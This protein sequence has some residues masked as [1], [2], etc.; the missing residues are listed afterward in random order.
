VIGENIS[1]IN[2]SRVGGASLTTEAFNEA[3]AQ[4]AA[5]V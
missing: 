2:L 3:V 1:D 5:Q 4:I